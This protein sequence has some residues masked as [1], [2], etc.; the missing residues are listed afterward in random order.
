MAVSFPPRELLTPS[1]PNWHCR[2]AD[3]YC[4]SM[5][6]VRAVFSVVLTLMLVV[7]TSRSML[8]PESMQNELPGSYMVMHVTGAHSAMPGKC[9]RCVGKALCC[10]V[11]HGSSA[12]LPVTSKVMR[13]STRPRTAPFRGPQFKSPTI[14]PSPPPP[15]LGDL[16]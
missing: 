11:C 1:T 2:L 4:R 5:Q 16:T 10:A 15:K 7:G 13:V 9:H 3:L 8:S 12:V 14:S 6:N